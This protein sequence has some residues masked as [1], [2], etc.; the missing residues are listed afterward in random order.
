[1]RVC[2]GHQLAVLICLLAWQ[3]P[4]LEIHMRD[5]VLS[6]QHVLANVFSIKETQEVHS[7]ENEFYLFPKLFDNYILKTTTPK[8]R[9]RNLHFKVPRS[10][11][12]FLNFCTLLTSTTTVF[13][14]KGVEG[15]RMER[16]KEHN[17][18][19]NDFPKIRTLF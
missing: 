4:F 15:T 12:I 1:M 16:K 6:L 13:S 14:T 7:M 18:L 9:K 10:L 17:S 19:G 8:E 11:T 2:F 3:A 5:F